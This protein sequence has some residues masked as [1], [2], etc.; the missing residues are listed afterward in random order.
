MTGGSQTLDKDAVAAYLRDYLDGFDQ[1]FEVDKFETGQSNPTFRLRTHAGSYVLRRK[2]PG[3]LLKSA[4]AVEREYRV[5]KALK[6][7]AVPVAQMHLLCEDEEVIG[8]PFYVMDHVEGRN[9]TDPSMPGFENAT[10]TG[11]IKE[12]NRVLA[13]LH[14]IDIAKYSLLDYGPE[15]NYFQRQLARWTKQYQAS[16]TENISEMNTLI[17]ALKEAMPADDGQRGLVHGDYRIDNMIFAAEGTEC[18]AVLDWELSTIGHPYA[19]LAGV[20]MQWQLPPGREGRGLAGV[21][22]RDLGLPTDQEFI[23][24]YCK[25]RDLPGIENFGFYLSFSFFRMAGILQGVLKR[26]LDGNAS[27]PQRAI[28]LGGYVK[29]FARQGLDALEN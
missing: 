22:R 11:I 25:R 21:N 23:E 7:S 27:N 8:S 16:E 5:Q 2:P 4:H 18:R 19:D 13:E 28:M 10:R 17:R 20:I 14:Q 3:V 15:G 9:I 6:N 26:A 1:D 12:M 29:V 24:S